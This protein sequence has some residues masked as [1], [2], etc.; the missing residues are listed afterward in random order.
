MLKKNC[1]TCKWFNSQGVEVRKCMLEHDDAMNRFFKMDMPVS[2][3][4]E[5]PCCDPIGGFTEATTVKAPLLLQGPTTPPHLPN[6]TNGSPPL[7]ICGGTLFD[8]PVSNE[9][10]DIEKKMKLSYNC[11]LKEL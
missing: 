10:L 4:P 8:L 7:R 3:C 9:V 5:M 6:Q 11:K 1:L 2:M